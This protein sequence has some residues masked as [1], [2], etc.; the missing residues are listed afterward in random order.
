[1]PDEGPGFDLEAATLE[2]FLKLLKRR[3]EGEVPDRE[4]PDGLRRA[5]FVARLREARGSRYPFPKVVR[6]VVAAFAHGADVVCLRRTTSSAVEPPETAGVTEERQR[7]VYDELRAG[8]ERGL[9][10][11]GLAHEVPVYEGFLCRSVRSGESG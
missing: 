8:I 5:V 7:A 10:E 9:E 1:M 6:R 4:D 2:E 11:A 3:E